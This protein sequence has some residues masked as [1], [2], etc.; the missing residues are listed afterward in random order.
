MSKIFK[1]KTSSE[2][3]GF[4]QLLVDFQEVSFFHPMQY[5]ISQM[6]IIKHT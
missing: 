3:L 1:K 2:Y 6:V 5:F 4:L